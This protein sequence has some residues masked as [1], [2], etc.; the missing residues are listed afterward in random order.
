MR[1][2]LASKLPALAWA[3]LAAL[4]LPAQADE[5]AAWTALRS[6]QAVVALM[7]HAD[8]PG[9]GD[10]PGWRLDDCRTQRNLSAEG[11]AQ[12]R[13]TGERFSAERVSIARLMSSPWCRCIDTARLMNVGPVQTDPTF[14]N[15]FVLSDQHDALTAGARKVI[16]AWQGPGA[17]LVVTHGANIRALT[18]RSLASGEVIVVSAGKAGVASEIGVLAVPRSLTRQR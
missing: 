17:L 8:A 7:R 16:A 11:R 6:G 18:G 4:P 15:A 2:A 9:V 5:A 14:S 1:K 12:A 10:P 3:L 13:A